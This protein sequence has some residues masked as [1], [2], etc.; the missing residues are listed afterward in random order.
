[1]T[2]ISEKQLEA[3]RSNAKLGG[4]KTEEG[5]SI[6]KMNAIKHGIL[7]IEVLL[8][9]ENEGELIGLGKRL[10]QEL[11]PTSEIEMILVERIISGIWR[12]KRALRGEKEMIVEDLK[13]Y[14]N[15]DQTFGS[16]LSSSYASSDSYGKFTR[17]EASLERGIYKAL[18]E[19]QRIKA[20][21]N[22]EV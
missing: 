21:K 14:F 18:H 2:E 11:K 3:N 10:R 19:L 17:Y 12:L 4:V 5:K 22:G 9:G 20:V 6:S 7:S 1:M 13:D 15:K 8:D 16:A